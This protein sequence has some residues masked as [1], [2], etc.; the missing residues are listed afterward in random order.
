VLRT[1]EARIVSETRREYVHAGS[2]PASL[3]GTVAETILASRVL[4]CG[5]RNP[6]NV[7]AARVAT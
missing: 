1:R 6:G 4:D 2:G 3:R 5:I 7:V